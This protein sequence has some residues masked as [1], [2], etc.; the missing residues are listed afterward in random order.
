VNIKNRQARA[1]ARAKTMQLRRMGVPCT[2]SKWGYMSEWNPPMSMLPGRRM[3][4][5]SW[6]SYRKR[7]RHD[8][9]L[10]HGEPMVRLTRENA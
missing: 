9:R 7:A 2:P 6:Q 5:I 3:T 10:S 4:H 1:K 8:F